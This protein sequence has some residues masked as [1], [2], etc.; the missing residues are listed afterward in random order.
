MELV[1][2]HPTG[3]VY[4]EESAGTL[5]TEAVRGEG[6]ILRNAAGE[7]FMERY[8]HERLE[9][10]TRDRVAL[11][12][13]TEIAEGRGTEHGG[14]LLDISH[15]DRDLIL[16]RLPRMYRQ[17]L[18]LAMLDISTTPMEVAPTAHYSMG[19]VRVNGETHAT[20]VAGL[21]AVGECAAGVHGANRLGGNSLAECLVFGRIV[22][23]EATRASAALD[24]QV[25]DR[26]AIEEAREEVEAM[27]SRRGDEFARPLQRALRDLMS[28]HCGVVRSEE[29]LRQGLRALD[30]IR[31]RT[32]ALEVRP[33]IAGYAD[34]AHAFD[35][36]GS[37]LAARATLECALERRETRGAH[38]RVDYP[39]QDPL[40]RVNLTWVPD[41]DI[42]REPIASPSP[43]LAALAGEVELEVPGR[44]LE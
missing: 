3:M 9:L 26:G 39:E 33:D 12:N 28:E 38:N 30:G 19:G 37:L 44:L 6:G 34:L 20:D 21:F 18:D 24:V 23:A 2:F 7:R 17:F 4:P 13:Y 27:L 41:G 16:E 22:G 36:Y 31:A 11:A 25:R 10:S 40:L 42:V 5:V 8:D 1:Q 14:V 32:N 29:G 35:L 15:L 43:A